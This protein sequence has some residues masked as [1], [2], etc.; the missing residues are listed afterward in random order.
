MNKKQEFN[1]GGTEI[2]LEHT[3]L[4]EKGRHGQDPRVGP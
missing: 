1:G 4:S 3:V 2:I